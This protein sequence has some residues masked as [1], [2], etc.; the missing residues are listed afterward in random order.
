MKGKLVLFLCL[1]F[2][3]VLIGCDTDPV[4]DPLKVRIVTEHLAWITGNPIHE[5]AVTIQ[6]DDEKSLYACFLLG[7]IWTDGYNIE[8]KPSFQWYYDGEKLDY[9]YWSSLHIQG[10]GAEPNTSDIRVQDGKKIKVVVNLGNQTGSAETTITI[11]Q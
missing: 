2:G 4:Y 3:Y 10:P 5:S 6:A 9:G 1:F 11:Q 8:P 7:K